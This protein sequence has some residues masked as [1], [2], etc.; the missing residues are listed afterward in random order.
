MKNRS[1]NGSMQRWKKVVLWFVGVII[2][3]VV[4]AL[5]FIRII[6]SFG[7]MSVTKTEQEDYAKRTSNYRNGKF[8]NE[9]EF[10]VMEKVPEGAEDGVLSEKGTTPEDEI[11]TETPLFLSDFSANEITY[12]WL[13]HSTLL[14]QIDGKNILV[15][16]ILSDISSPVSFVGNKRFSKVPIEADELPEIDIVLYTHDHFDHLDYPTLKKIDSR[17][18]QYVVPLGVENHLERF[19]V[20]KSK[21]S[22]MAWWESETY[23]DL[24]IACTPARHY[25]GRYMLDNFSTLWCSYALLT[26]NHKIFLSG[27]TGY[28]D[29]FK[30]IHEKYGDFDIVFTDG[31]QY[32][33]RWP[34]VHMN[35]EEAYKSLEI[36]GAEYAVPVHWAAFRL[37]NHPWDDSVQRLVKAAENGNVTILTPKL[38]ETMKLENLDDYQERWYEQI[39]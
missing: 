16:P 10:S 11:P 21:I 20:D 2:F 30:Q 28:D 5:I 1:R 12:T 7:Y 31:A 27:D 15:D 9:H 18:K 13:G 14:I 26:E 23:G 25:S 39:Q 19:G 34:S 3:V 38:G 4:F 8:E 32:D 36:L 22:N 35:P 29:H 17:V 24:T 37:A 6:P 33:L